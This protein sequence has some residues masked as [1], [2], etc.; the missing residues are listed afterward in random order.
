MELMPR[1]GQHWVEA[2]LRLMLPET[3]ERR[4]RQIS[5]ELLV[6]LPGQPL[7]VEFPLPADGR[8]EPGTRLR[9]ERGKLSV[10]LERITRPTED[11]LELRL[12][13]TLQGGG[14]SVESFRGWLLK[15][16]IFLVG[17]EGERIEATDKRTYRFRDGEAGVACRF[18]ITPPL[19]GFRLHY[20][21]V[22]EVSE[23]RFPFTL[24]DFPLP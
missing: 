2:D 10:E 15:N 16:E 5:G 17:P 21:A 6:A 8:L 19:D 3:A 12:A 23:Q 9:G 11:S 18:N 20:L 1:R 4:V 14:G 7:E 24:N 22:E 13:A